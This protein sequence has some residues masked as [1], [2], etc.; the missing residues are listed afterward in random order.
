MA[1]K[2]R[3]RKSK[4]ESCVEPRLYEIRKWARDGCTEAEM[5]VRLGVSESSFNDYKKQ[6]PEFSESLKEGKAVADYKVED[7]LFKR[8]LGYTYE[9]LTYSTHTRSA[10][11]MDDFIESSLTLFDMKYPEATSEERMSYIDS[12]P[13]EARKLDKVVTK[14]VQP[15]TTAAIFWLK[16]RN[17]SRWRDKQNIEHSGE[18]KAIDPYANLT[19]EEL[20]RLAYGN[21]NTS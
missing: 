13:R 21:D 19:E 12:L 7:A 16:N 1:A 20:R 4:Y 10:E 8:A 6:F 9:E 17:P 18:I 5:C 2:K 11:E 14:H 15:D 3:G